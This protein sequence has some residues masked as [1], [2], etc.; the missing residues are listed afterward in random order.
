MIVSLYQSHSL[1]SKRGDVLTREAR[2][3]S[4]VVDSAEWSALANLPSLRSEETPDHVR[5]SLRIEPHVLN[6]TGP[7][8][9]LANHEVLRLDASFIGQSEFPQRHFKMCALRG[10]WIEVD[11][12][13]QKI[14]SVGG[15]FAVV[16]NAIVP[17]IVKR[18]VV[19]RL[20]RWGAAPQAVEATNVVANMAGSFPVPAL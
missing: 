9:P 17:G 10:V 14:T 8:E 12:Q 3:A 7:C 20:K 11:G 6:L 5:A 19:E 2:C 18:N 13:K 1:R 4:S 15:G 16:E